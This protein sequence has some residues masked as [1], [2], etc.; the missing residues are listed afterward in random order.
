MCAT[1]HL[2]KRSVPA[3]HISG[4]LLWKADRW[5]ARTLPV[6]KAIFVVGREWRLIGGGVF[7]C[8]RA[9]RR[10][11][12]LWNDAG[13]Y[14]SLRRAGHYKASAAMLGSGCLWD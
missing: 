14:F 9:P 7:A 5:Q 8:D 4:H 10:V 12:Y 1:Q 3:S 11:G 6:N 13:A 2:G